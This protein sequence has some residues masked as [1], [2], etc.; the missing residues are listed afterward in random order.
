MPD[1]WAVADW[2]TAYGITVSNDISEDVLLDADES[3]TNY[4]TAE[5]YA[6]ALAGGDYGRLFTRVNGELALY[7]LDR[8]PQVGPK[9]VTES[10]KEYDGIKKYVQKYSSSSIMADWTEDSILDQLIDFKD[11]DD[12]D[13]AFSAVV[14]WGTGRFVSGSLVVDESSDDE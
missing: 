1:F 2:K 13:T 9:Q 14:P 6:D 12:S 3:M 4:C 5:S 10:R 11:V 8:R 7:Y